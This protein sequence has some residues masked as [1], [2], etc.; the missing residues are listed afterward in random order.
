MSERF[1]VI[2]KKVFSYLDY[3][4]LIACY[5]VSENYRLFAR[6]ELL[7]LGEIT[8]WDISCHSELSL[9]FIREFKENLNWPILL[10]CHYFSE[11]FIGEH[12]CYIDWNARDLYERCI[13]SEGFIENFKEFINWKHMYDI[14]GLSIELQIK[15]SEYLEVVG[16]ESTRLLSCGCQ[17]CKNK[18]KSLAYIWG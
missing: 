16:I 7:K 15:Y 6:E 11:E 4:A 17:I 1:Y 8:W 18:E 5:N 13:F 10:M 12:A 14:Q 2:A 9:D 3:Q